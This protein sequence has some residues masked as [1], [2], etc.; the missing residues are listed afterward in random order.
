MSGVSSRRRWH[1]SRRPASLCDGG[2]PP[3]RRR[4]SSRARSRA[5]PR[6]G[7]CGSIARV[8]FEIAP[9]VSFTPPRRVPAHD[10]GRRPAQLQHHGL[11][12][13]GVWGALR[14][15]AQL[16]DGPTRARSSDLD[17]GARV[18]A[19]TA[20]NVNSQ[21]QPRT[22]TAG[23]APRSPTRPRRSTTSWRRRSRSSRSAASSPSSTRSSSTR[24]LYSA[25]ALAFV[26]SRSATT[27]AAA[28]ETACNDPASFA[29]RRRRRR[30][31]RLRPRVQVLPGRLL[32][33]RRRVPRPPVLL[34]PRGLRLARRRA[35]RELPGRQDQLAGRHVQVQ[36]V[37]TVSV[38]FSFPTRRSSARKPSQ[39]RRRSERDAHGAA[40][41]S[42]ECAWQLRLTRLRDAAR[43]RRAPIRSRERSC[44]PRRARLP[45]S[46]SRG[47]RGPRRSGC[48]R[49]RSP[50][51]TRSCA[52]AGTAASSSCARSV[53]TAWKRAGSFTSS[54]KRSTPS[55]MP[56]CLCSSRA[57][58]IWT[59]GSMN[60]A[61]SVSHLRE[62]AEEL[63]DV[64]VLV[65]GAP[66]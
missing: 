14:A 56:G 25:A 30:S 52:S 20:N 63:V 37:V 49:G 36:P 3:A 66:S 5:L 62:P 51:R 4:S 54:R 32:V 65:D 45:G 26:G 11:A 64:L 38:G 10:P 16:D 35:E 8:A 46:A 15:V 33:A 44:G 55:R 41:V 60:F 21:R 27:A 24:D 39:R 2:Q 47:M 13:V 9:T 61:Y 53:D 50:R 40:P 6:C 7:T 58:R 48:A 42:F 17:A 28:G 31:R 1:R 29:A 19:L 23:Y 22:A 57:A 59:L 34:E 18:T 43:P 12:R